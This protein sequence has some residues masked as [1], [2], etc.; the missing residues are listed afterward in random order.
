MGWPHWHAML[1]SGGLDER[2]FALVS[3]AWFTH[4]GF[5]KFYRVRQDSSFPVAQYITK[6]LT[7][8]V[9]AVEFAESDGAVWPATQMILNLRRR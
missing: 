5:A 2:L 1:A 4:H 6:Y 9:G 8:G 3:S 7:K